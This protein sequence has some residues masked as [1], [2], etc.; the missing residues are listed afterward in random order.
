[1]FSSALKWDRDTGMSPFLTLSPP[2][3]PNFTLP[4]PLWAAIP[5]GQGRMSTMSQRHHVSSSPGWNGGPSLLR[6]IPLVQLQVSPRLSLCMGLLLLLQP[7]IIFFPLLCE[8][9]RLLPVTASEL[10]INYPIWFGYRRIY[11]RFTKNTVFWINDF[12]SGLSASTAP[13]PCVK[14]MQLK[15]VVI[16]CL[17]ES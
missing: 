12:L 5:S 8:F 14:Q 17:Q 16:V 13:L 7:K 3:S 4:S 2:L 10:V 6:E 1:M 9:S 15:E 11:N